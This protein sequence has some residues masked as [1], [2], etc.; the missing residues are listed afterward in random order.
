[1][2]K[3]IISTD[4]GTDIDDALAVYIAARNPSIDL[5]AVWVTNGDVQ[6][7]AR[8]ARKLLQYSTRSAPKTRVLLGEPESLT[9]EP[10]PFMHG[11]EQSF[12]SSKE[13]EQACR[14]NIEPDGL[15]GIKQ[16][17]D[18]E[19][20]LKIASI[21]PMT[22]LA[23]LISERPDAQNAIKKVYAMACRTGKLEHNI[24]FDIQAAREVFK[25]DL[26]IVI[27]SGD[28]CD[29]YR[30]QSDDLL[31]CDQQ[32]RALEFINQ[33]AYA[34][35]YRKERVGLVA[36]VDEVLRNPPCIKEGTDQEKLHAMYL[37]E[38]LRQLEIKLD[39][40]SVTNYSFMFR[41]LVMTNPNFLRYKQ[42]LKKTQI[43][44]FA[45]HDVYTIF[46][47]L[48]PSL[49]QTDKVSV[50]IDDEGV[51]SFSKGGRHDLVID[52]DYPAFKEFIYRGL[53]LTPLKDSQNHTPDLAGQNI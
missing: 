23:R 42:Q 27:L 33:M 15:H 18:Q 50:D 48:Y 14:W 4:I 8:I 12:I 16:L 39:I 17:M 36:L 31:C 19:T 7:R 22:N 49:I 13:R 44:S 3:L 47:L 41:S 11:Y 26:S 21:A 28:V 37:L 38:A 10:K 29:R 25:S 24:R 34:W 9:G 32:G 46:A 43:S 2:H 40:D 30:L 5:K 20:D 1:M 53:Q 51:T 35:K 6:T 45:V 52:L